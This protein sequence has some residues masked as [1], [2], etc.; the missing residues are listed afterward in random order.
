MLAVLCLT[1]AAAGETVKDVRRKMGSRFEIT[2]VHRDEA[3]ARQAIEAAYAEIERIEDMIS[4]WRASSETS[5]VNRLAGVS[6]QPVSQELFNLVRRSVKL[7]QLTDGAF[8]LTFA[9]VGKLWD[10]NNPSPTVPEEA[11]IRAA[12]SH[13]GYQKIVLDSAARSIYLDDPGARIGFGAIGKGYAANRAVWVLK[14]QGMAGGVVNAG[15]DLVAFGEQEDG[16]PWNIGI[17]HPRQRDRIFARL[18][19]TETAVVTSGDYES[20]FILDGKRYAHIIDPR[21]GFPVDDLGSATN[22]CP[23]GFLYRRSGFERARQ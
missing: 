16:T 17:A 15:G 10:F 1:T 13:V 8:D 14:E 4:S 21:T 7:S 5:A 19:L 18:H 22:V 23:D 12:L 11:A 20:F 6:P 2:V 3:T 9:G